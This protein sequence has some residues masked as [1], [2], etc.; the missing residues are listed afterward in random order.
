[1][2]TEDNKPMKELRRKRGRNYR[3]GQLAGQ[4]F[5]FSY[6][7]CKAFPVL[8]MRYKEKYPFFVRDVTAV[9]VSITVCR[10]VAKT[11]QK[12]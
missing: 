8:H 3:L 7:H 5:P 11:L 1:V 6:T 4:V 12:E 9:L 2:E 10:I